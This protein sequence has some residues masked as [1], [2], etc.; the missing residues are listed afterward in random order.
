MLGEHGVSLDAYALYTAVVLALV[1]LIWYGL[2]AL[3]IRC[4]P[5]D[6]GALLAAFFLVAFPV[7]EVAAWIPAGPLSGWLTALCIVALLVFGLL[8]P[9]GRFAPRWTRRLAGACV[10]QGVLIGVLTSLS[11]PAAASVVAIFL[12]FVISFAVV[13]AQ[14]YRYRFFS[15]WVQRRQTKWAF[16]GLA[17]AILGIVVS[18][19]PST[20]APAQFTNGSLYAAWVNTTGTALLV[21]AIPITIAIAVL[22]NHLWDI[23]RLINRAL[24]YAVLSVALAAIY[25]GSVLALQALFRVVARD[26]STLA[27]ALSTLVIGAL[28]G[29][30][31]RRVQVGID[32]RFYRSK[33]DAARVLAAFGGRLRDE[34]DLA[35]LSHDLLFVVQDTLHPEH[36]SLWLPDGGHEPRSDSGSGVGSHE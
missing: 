14:I 17:V 27:I 18:W 24:V 28:F 22:R 23:D 21:S 6:R 9:D 25:I 33:Y 36:I 16:F 10:G 3:I 32:R 4:K 34:V 2:A 19:L 1:W 15:S 5:Q 35:H 26:N 29:P 20:L 30:L 11:L 8:F 12:F 13:G 7:W 31:R